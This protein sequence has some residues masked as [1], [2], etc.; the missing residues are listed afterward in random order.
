MDLSRDMRFLYEIG[1]MRYFPRAWVGF[2][3]ANV[4]N[5]AEHTFRVIWLALIIARHEGV[6]DTGKIVQL[7]LVH[8]LSE[9]RAGDLNMVTRLYSKRDEER[10]IADTFDGV[11]I[12]EEY[13]ALFDEY[14]ARET[15]EARVVKDADWIEADIE[16][17][18]LMERGCTL[19]HEYFERKRASGFRAK[20][21][22]ETGRRIWDMLGDGRSAQWVFDGPNRLSRY[23]WE[24][25]EQNT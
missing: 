17:V 19:M 6:E 23:D 24:E 14:E 7:A 11:S 13:R 5:N 18:E 25:G 20:L 4:Q 16:A 9:I 12:G 22:T 2:V 1:S 10:A 21:H 8:D 15:L 3:G